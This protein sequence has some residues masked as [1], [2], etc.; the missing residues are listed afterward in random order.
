MD[1]RKGTCTK[2]AGNNS[3][4]RHPWHSFLYKW[5]LDQTELHH[6]DIPEKVQ[7][8]WKMQFVKPDFPACKR[9]VKSLSCSAIQKPWWS[10]GRVVLGEGE[11]VTSELESVWAEKRYICV[12]IIY[13][14]IYMMSGITYHV[15]SCYVS[16]RVARSQLLARS[17]S[18]V[19]RQWHFDPRRQTPNLRVGADWIWLVGVLEGLR[20]IIP[21]GSGSMRLQ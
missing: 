9:L 4:N 18:Q 11:K 7:K 8:I 14:Y 13:I 20:S 6:V 19:L 17:C 10:Q 12:Y 5:S 2:A 1:H 15:T 3:E 21:D 16:L